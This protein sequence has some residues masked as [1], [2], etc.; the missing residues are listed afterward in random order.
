[1]FLAWVHT[2]SIEMSSF[3]NPQHFQ[4]SE[5]SS[6]LIADRSRKATVNG[7]FVK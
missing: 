5:K 4:S 2:E 3:S 6:V 7:L 1:M